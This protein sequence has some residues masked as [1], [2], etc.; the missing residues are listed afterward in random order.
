MNKRAKMM[1]L[2]GGRDK[3]ADRREEEMLREREKGVEHRERMLD[4]REDREMRS[5]IMNDH[6]REAT[7]MNG[8]R[9]MPNRYEMD[10]W[11]NPMYNPYYH[12]YP[13]YNRANG[14]MGRSG[15]RRDGRVRYMAN[16]YY[17]M[18]D[19]E[20]DAGMDYSVMYG[21]NNATARQT[22]GNR[23]GRRT[24]GMGGGYSGS[25]NGIYN[26]GYEFSAN[27]EI[28]GHPGS[29]HG[30]VSN[31]GEMMDMDEKTAKK[32]VMSM[33]NEDG[34]VGQHWTKQQV[35]D[36][37]KQQG[38]Q[39]DDDM[40]LWIAANAMYSDYQRVAKRYGVDKP[41]FYI[42]MADAFLND[43]DTIQGMD[44]LS[45]YYNTIVEK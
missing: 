44:K 27:G 33:E 14:G 45:M 22:G 3:E 12:D 19:Y 15:M 30:T 18:D 13:M 5:R 38:I 23:G 28:G 1:L 9:T 29:V 26:H 43:K 17:P 16:T 34:T 42:A 10:E 4:K 20:D 25:M 40:A 31:M 24:G 32:W 11:N 36:V 37:A 21:V 41:E 35:K 39:T 2:T 6:E 8:G 7:I